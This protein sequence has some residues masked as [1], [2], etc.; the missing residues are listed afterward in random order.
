[1]NTTG[2]AS[3][4]VFHPTPRSALIGSLPNS[5][6]GRWNVPYWPSLMRVDLRSSVVVRSPRGDCA[7]LT[8]VLIAWGAME[9]GFGC[10]SSSG[11]SAVGLD[12]AHLEHFTDRL[13]WV[14]DRELRSRAF[15]KSTTAADRAA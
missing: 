3:R 6:R 8:L 14:S 15:A 12:G 4:S 11:F 2:P 5:S 1:M 10:P 13:I 9:H 7:A